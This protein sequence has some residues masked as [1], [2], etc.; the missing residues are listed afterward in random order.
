MAPYQIPGIHATRIYIKSLS[1]YHLDS[2]FIFHQEPY[3]TTQAG[4][5][6]FYEHVEHFHSSIYLLSTCSVRCCQVEEIQ[7]QAIH[8]PVLQEFTFTPL[9]LP[10]S[11]SIRQIPG[12]LWACFPLITTLTFCALP[13]HFSHISS[14]A[15][16]LKML[17]VDHQLHLKTS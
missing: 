8:S 4:Y 9:L 3:V 13:Q 7:R 16:L 10:P 14:I 6:P 15:L 5:L 1:S 12:N 2:K 17:S 11:L